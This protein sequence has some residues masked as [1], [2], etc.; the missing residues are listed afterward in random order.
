MQLHAF[1]MAVCLERSM[2]AGSCCC[3]A[4]HGCVADHLVRHRGSSLGW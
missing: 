2:F 4:L 1:H 3:L